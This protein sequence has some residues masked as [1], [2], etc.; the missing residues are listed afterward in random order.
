[1]QNDVLLEMY[2]S[3][4][5]GYKCMMVTLFKNRGSVPGKQGNIMAVR[6]DGKTFGTVGGGAIE[7]QVIKDSIENLKKDSDFGGFGGGSS[8]G[9]GGFSGGGGS[10]GGGGAGRSF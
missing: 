5:D 1:M 9:W 3:L 4:E 8:G 2:K 6:E 7:H 10:S